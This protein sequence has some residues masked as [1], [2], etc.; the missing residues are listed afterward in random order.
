M[1]VAP[2]TPLS[3]EMKSYILSLKK[4]WKWRTLSLVTFLKGVHL[5]W[6]VPASETFKPRVVDRDM[7]CPQASISVSEENFASFRA[8]TEVPFHC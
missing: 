7:K 3:F 2:W 1:S 4:S 8:S 5:S 6:I